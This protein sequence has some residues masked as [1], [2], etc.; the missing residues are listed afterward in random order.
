MII[1]CWL[2][3]GEIIFVNEYCYNFFGFSKEEMV[4]KLVFDIIVFRISSFG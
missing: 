4:G 2:L 3:M 1:V